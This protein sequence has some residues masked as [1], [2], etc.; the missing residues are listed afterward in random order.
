MLGFTSLNTTMAPKDYLWNWGVAPYP[1]PVVYGYSDDCWNLQTWE[2]INFTSGTLVP[3]EGY[4]VA[5]PKAGTVFV[6]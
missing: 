2:L 5:F 1:N 6:P 3:G 4:F